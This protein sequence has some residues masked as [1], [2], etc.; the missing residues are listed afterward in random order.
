MKSIAAAAAAYFVQKYTANLDN[1]ELYLGG[2]I[3]GLIQEDDLQ[4]IQKC[5]KD[6]TTLEKEFADAIYKYEKGDI[7][8]AILEFKGVLED[9]PK[10]FAEC[11]EMQGDI[12][13]IEKWGEIF[14]DPQ[15]L[16]Q[17][18]TFNV[19]KNLFAITAD[20]K[21]LK[22]DIDTGDFYN[23]GVEN[24]DILVKALGPVPEMN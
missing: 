13:R 5:L 18:L 15:H 12:T 4:E 20:I 17:T 21:T 22:N 16:I 1:V 7:V 19:A 23:A 11:K 9:I 6:G 3:Y 2:L 8:D 24:A 14:E 10:E